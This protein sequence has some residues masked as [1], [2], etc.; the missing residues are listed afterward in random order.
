MKHWF[1]DS[2]GNNIH[3]WYMQLPGADRG[4]VNSCSPH[5][6]YQFTMMA[7]RGSEDFE[8]MGWKFFS[9]W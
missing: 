3:N 2:K 6:G 1:V 7:T 5:R 9:V 8:V 4:T